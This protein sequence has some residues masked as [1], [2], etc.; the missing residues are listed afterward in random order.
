MLDALTVLPPKARA[1]IY[2]TL[3]VANVVLTPLMA[4]GYVPSLYGVIVLGLLNVFGGTTAIAN[5]KKTDGAAP[6]P[7]A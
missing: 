5:V 7:P 3:I 6:V 4:A 1:G 2:L